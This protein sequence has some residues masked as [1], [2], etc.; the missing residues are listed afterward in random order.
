MRKRGETSGRPWSFRIVH[1]I[2]YECFPRRVVSNI[3][4]LFFFQQYERVDAKTFNRRIRQ[5]EEVTLSFEE[6]QWKSWWTAEMTV[7]LVEKEDRVEEYFV[8]RE[9][10]TSGYGVVERE[11]FLGTTQQRVWKPFERCN[12][13]LVNLSTDVQEDS[14]CTSEYLLIPHYEYV[15]HYLHVIFLIILTVFKNCF[16]YVGVE[17]QMKSS[18]FSWYFW[19][20]LT[21]KNYK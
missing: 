10:I 1:D 21:I 8:V 20:F 19:S 17:G 13:C 12:S 4:F 15:Y 16:G 11:T 3:C 7:W 2:P 14:I 9:E 6:A 5:L 18:V